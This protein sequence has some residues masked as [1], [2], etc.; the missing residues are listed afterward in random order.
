MRQKSRLR[1]Q[2]LLALGHKKASHLKNASFSLHF[3][4][5]QRGP[6]GA[7]F[8]QL[9]TCSP[10][11]AAST[12]LLILAGRDFSFWVA[13]SAT[14]HLSVPVKLGFYMLVS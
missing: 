8:S 2:Q 3:A 12:L 11:A 13:V 1:Q 10:E 4:L 7:E 5:F 9:G 6:H 14:D